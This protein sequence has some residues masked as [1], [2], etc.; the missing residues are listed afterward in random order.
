M[1]TLTSVPEH[2]DT[3]EPATSHV[4]V[5]AAKHAVV[6]AT[7]GGIVL[8]AMRF[9]SPPYDVE[10][11][12]RE[13]EM[14]ADPE[15]ADILAQDQHLFDAVRKVAL[16]RV[17][18]INEFNNLLVT[19]YLLAVVVNGIRAGAVPLTRG[20]P[21]TLFGL[22]VQVQQRMQELSDAVHNNCKTEM[23]LRNFDTACSAVG[24]YCRSVVNNTRI[25]AEAMAE[26]GG[27]RS[28]QFSTKK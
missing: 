6:G 17:R 3:S 1:S 4:L 20:V 25:D 8:A 18:A 9:F 26:K 10:A 14:Y 15:I 7:V 2:G 5:R 27:F 12:R 16:V 23:G 28:Q 22:A 21:R 13:M 11:A 19:L 24:H